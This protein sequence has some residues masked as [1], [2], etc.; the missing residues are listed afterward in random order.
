MFGDR[1]GRWRADLSRKLDE[2]LDRPRTIH[3][4]PVRVINTRP[5]IA[6]PRVLER[7]EAALDLIARHA[8]WRLRR[9]QRDFSAIV[10]QR[11]PC[12]AAYDPASHTCLV[13]LTFLV[14][15]AFTPAQIAASIVHEGTH[16]R[17]D[18]MGVH[19]PPGERAREE[20]LC[21]KAEVELGLVVPDGRAVLERAMQ[22]MALDDAGVAPVIDWNEAARRVEAADHA[23]RTAPPGAQPR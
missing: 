5:D 10:V 11:F 9:M 22:A 7:L 17:L 18:R 6:T 14:N 4:L 20:R 13:E 19:V 8:P 21:R 16:A 15:P 23:A 3:G 12:R 1:L 2:L